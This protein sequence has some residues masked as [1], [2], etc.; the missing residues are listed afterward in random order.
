MFNFLKKKPLKEGLEKAK[1]LNLFS[2]AEYLQLK[3]QRA[4]KEFKDFIAKKIKKRR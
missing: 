1:Q 2:E 3:S 4:E